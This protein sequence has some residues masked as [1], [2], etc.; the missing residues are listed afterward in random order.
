MSEMKTKFLFDT[1]CYVQFSLLH[2]YAIVHY[3][4]CRPSAKSPPIYRLR[5]VLHSITSDTDAVRQRIAK[6]ITTACSI[7][8][9]AALRLWDNTQRFDVRVVVT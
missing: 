8:L 1:D 2:A 4:L 3:Q 5:R 7:T 9:T 6:Y